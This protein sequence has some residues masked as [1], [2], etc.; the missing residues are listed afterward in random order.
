MKR[1]VVP[2]LIIAFAVAF[3]LS[4]FASRHPDGLE[5]VAKK[6]GFI[7]A[8]EG[9]KILTAPMPGYVMPGVK[10]GGLATAV[11]GLAGTLITFGAAFGVGYLIRRKTK[12]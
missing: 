3:F 8:G 10:N 9:K 11:S 6:K 4:P 1:F 12:A 7:K 5:R 2:G